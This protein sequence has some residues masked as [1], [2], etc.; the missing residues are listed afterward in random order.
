MV[1][2]LQV[3]CHQQN[4]CDRT[5]RHKDVKWYVCEGCW[6]KW[7]RGVVNFLS[8]IGGGVGGDRKSKKNVWRDL[9]GFW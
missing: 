2:D 5:L 1:S 7:E 8:P 6:G 9:G 4:C 3:A